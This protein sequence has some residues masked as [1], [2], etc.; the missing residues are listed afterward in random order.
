VGAHWLV[1]QEP[2][3][4]PFS[5]LVKDGRTEWGGVR[6]FEA[7]NHLMAMK[8]G[9]RVLYY[10]SVGEKAIVG[11]ARV[12]AGAHPDSTSDDP[13][14]VA[15]DL[16]PVRP[17]VE[18]VPLAVIRDDPELKS[19]PLVRQSRL[20]VMPVTEAAYRRVLELSRTK[21]ERPPPGERHVSR[22]R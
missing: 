9:D 15:V 10:H 11:V 1:K 17:L 22:S 4:Y 3:S 8:R 20:S 13:R 19:M 12:A 18:P 7:R 14:W 5:Q 2:S 6:N 16:A 21:L